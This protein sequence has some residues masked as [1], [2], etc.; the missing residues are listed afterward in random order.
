MVYWPPWLALELTG[1]QPLSGP[2]R[3]AVRW[4]KE[5]GRYGDSILPSTETWEALGGDAPTVE[6]QLVMVMARAW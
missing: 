5:L 4:E 1:A 6:L 2:W 3:L